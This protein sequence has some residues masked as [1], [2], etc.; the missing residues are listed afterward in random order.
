[1]LRRDGFT[2]IAEAVGSGN[3][4]IPSGLDHQGV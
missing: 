1:L 4:L 3:R 2:S